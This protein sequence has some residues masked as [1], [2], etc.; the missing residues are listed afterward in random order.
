MLGV[1]FMEKNAKKVEKSQLR[2]IFHLISSQWEHFRTYFKQIWEA[3]VQRY[4][5]DFFLPFLDIGHVTTLLINKSMSKI[6]LWAIYI[7]I[8]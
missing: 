3:T 8:T 7:Y 5:F 1:V 2:K 4:N 6:Y